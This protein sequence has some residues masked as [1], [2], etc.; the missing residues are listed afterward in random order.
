MSRITTSLLARHLPE[1]C[2]GQSPDEHHPD[3][4]SIASPLDVMGHH[5]CH[6]HQL[7]PQACAQQRTLSRVADLCHHVP[8]SLSRHRQTG[9]HSDHFSLPNT[10]SSCPQS[11]IFSSSISTSSSH[12]RSTPPQRPCSLH[13]LSSCKPLP[14]SFKSPPHPSRPRS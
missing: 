1:P 12:S 10:G 14:L 3:H 2:L 8:L 7:P 5:L 6:A 4:K 11:L 9:G 13:L